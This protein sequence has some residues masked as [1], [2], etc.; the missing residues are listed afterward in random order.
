MGPQSSLLIV[1]LLVAGSCGWNAA[2][3]TGCEPMGPAR[4]LPDVLQESSGVAWSR[5][6]DGILFSHND[7]GN[8]PSIYALNPA[9]EI[10]GEIPL[11]G[12]SEPGLG[13]HRDREVRGGR[14]HL[15]GRYRG[16]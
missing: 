8:Q 16:Q 2:G 13:G 14:L 5:S 1:S 6:G 3:I 12:R 11:D 15:S 4:A 10:L 9:G 7:G